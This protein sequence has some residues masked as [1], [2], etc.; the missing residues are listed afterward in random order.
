MNLQIIGL[1]Y[2]AAGVFVLGLFSFAVTSNQIKTISG[3]KWDGNRD[4]AAYIAYD[5]TDTAAGSMLLVIGFLFEWISLARTGFDEVVYRFLYMLLLLLL[6]IY[7]GLARSY[8][9]GV[10]L[11]TIRPVQPE[12]N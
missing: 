10:R 5:R 1:I 2:D 11:G 7:Y 3:S 4:L 6:I 8:I 12:S 9:A